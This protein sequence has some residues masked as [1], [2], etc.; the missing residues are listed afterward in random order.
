MPDRRTPRLLR[1]YVEHQDPIDAAIGTA[2]WAGL[3]A[4]L[5][6]AGAA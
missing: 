3:I 4:V 6:F 5:L 2:A 1:F